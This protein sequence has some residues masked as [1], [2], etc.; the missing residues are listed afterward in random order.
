[1]TKITGPTWRPQAKLRPGARDNRCR[2]QSKKASKNKEKMAHSPAQ[3][4]SKHRV[5]KKHCT[6]GT[7]T[8]KRA[9]QRR[10]QR[11]AS[12]RIA[13]EK[14]WRHSVYNIVT[15]DRK[16][17]LEADWHGGRFCK[18]LNFNYCTNFLMAYPRITSRCFIMAVGLNG[19]H[20][21]V[22]WAWL[23][24]YLRQSIDS[25]KWDFAV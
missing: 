15:E 9:H 19:M 22:L 6:E 7:N 12:A 4:S 5:K 23:Y 8:R 10:A 2:D 17:E 21:Y 20:D 1:M 11:D 3:K 25:L 16:P 18:F 14:F 13:A 24:S